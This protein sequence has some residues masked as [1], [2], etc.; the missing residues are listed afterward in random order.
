MRDVCSVRRE[1]GVMLVLGQVRWLSQATADEWKTGL[2]AEK[3][4]SYDFF[5]ANPSLLAVWKLAQMNQNVYVW[6]LLNQSSEA[7]FIICIIC[8]EHTL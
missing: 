7:K 2:D 1:S 4:E 8:T 6:T 3:P 5:A